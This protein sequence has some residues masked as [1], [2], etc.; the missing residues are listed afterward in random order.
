MFANR[1]DKDRPRLP[2]AADRQAGALAGDFTDPAARR[3]I[4]ASS[5]PAWQKRFHKGSSRA[6]PFPRHDVPIRATEA[7]PAA[8][9]LAETDVRR[10]S[11]L[12]RLDQWRICER[13][14]PLMQS[15][16]ITVAG[17]MWWRS[18][19][20]SPVTLMRNCH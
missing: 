20:S 8:S 3:R 18:G 14:I 4:H 10:V 11:C 12:R 13:G 19:W 16:R 17:S 9:N 7:L 6:V 5:P 1:S 15:R 2:H